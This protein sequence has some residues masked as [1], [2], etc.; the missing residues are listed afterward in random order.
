MD[1]QK[2][3]TRERDHRAQEINELPELPN[4]NYGPRLIEQTD[5]I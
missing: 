1:S 3:L 5:H 2:L 4:V